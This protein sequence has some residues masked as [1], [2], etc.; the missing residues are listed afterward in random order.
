MSTAPV[1]MIA[2]FGDLSFART[3]GFAAS[4]SPGRDTRRRHPDGVDIVAIRGL[5]VSGE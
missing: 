5:A 1:H 4:F 2:L 3:D